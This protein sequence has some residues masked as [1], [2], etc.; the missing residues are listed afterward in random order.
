VTEVFA[1]TVPAVAVNVPVVAPA[2]TIIDAGTVN[3]VLLSESVTVTPPEDAACASVTV[4][5]EVPLEGT[6]AGEHCNPV[7]VLGTAVMLM[8]AV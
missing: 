4:Q 5:V 3:A 7:T 8:E 1:V 2:A 6:V